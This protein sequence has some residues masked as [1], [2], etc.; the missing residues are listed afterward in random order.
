M[1]AQTENDGDKGRALLASKEFRN[2][3]TA[4]ESLERI[5]TSEELKRRKNLKRF[6][7]SKNFKFRMTEE[8]ICRVCQVFSVWDD[9]ED[10]ICHSKE[11]NGHRNDIPHLLRSL[12]E[13]LTDKQIED[14]ISYF[15]P[16]YTGSFELAD[17]LVGMATYYRDKYYRDAE[18]RW[19]VG[20]KQ[21]EDDY[22]QDNFHVAFPN[23]LYMQRSQLEMYMCSLGDK[24]DP[25]ELDSLF[26]SRR[27]TDSNDRKK[28]S[29]AFPVGD[30]GQLDM[31]E[32]LHTLLEDQTASRLDL[33]G[34]GEMATSPGST[35]SSP[36][37]IH[38]VGKKSGVNTEYIENLSPGPVLT[39]MNYAAK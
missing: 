33:M 35:I 18:G 31:T 36:A 17:F 39:E 15:D 38:I 16:K 6:K 12:G 7:E 30:D 20:D 14:T 21:L 2:S 29:L 25:V 8:Q 34:R 5:R 19:V 26:I 13:C 27:L 10:G 23:G 9:D 28:D 24:M 32:L 11:E 4:K 1:I 37:K 3:L 22:I